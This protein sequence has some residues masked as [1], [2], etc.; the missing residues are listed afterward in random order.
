MRQHFEGDGVGADGELGVAALEHDEGH[1]HCE[2]VLGAS[3]DDVVAVLGVL[4]DGN[5]VVLD[6]P[7]LAFTEL[8]NILRRSSNLVR[9]NVVDVGENVLCSE[10]VDPE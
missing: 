7:L 2:L 4:T 8:R 5:D 6:A 3:P 9:E 1:L 10:A